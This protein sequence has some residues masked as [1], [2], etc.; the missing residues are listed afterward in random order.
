M[1]TFLI[2]P[3]LFSTASLAT[4]LISRDEPQDWIAGEIA[5][6]KTYDITLQPSDTGIGKRGMLLARYND[7]EGRYLGSDGN[8]RYASGVKCWNDYFVVE[9][10][11]YNDPWRQASSKVYCTK[12]QSCQATQGVNNQVCETTSFEISAGITAEFVTASISRI[13]LID[14]V[15][16]ERSRVSCHL[17]PTADVKPEGVPKTKMHEQ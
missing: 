8:H 16:L 9:Q 6:A 10:N 17:E 11:L 5:Y 14:C 15:Y 13:D 2:F 3:L 7:G 12:S 1:R 4:P